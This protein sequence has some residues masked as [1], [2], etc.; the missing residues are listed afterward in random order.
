MIRRARQRR[1]ALQRG[2][3]AGAVSARK[4]GIDLERLLDLRDHRLRIVLFEKGPPYQGGAGSTHLL[5]EIAAARQLALVIRRHKQ[6]SAAL[7]TV[8]TGQTEVGYPLEPHVIDHTE[9]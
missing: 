2:A 7:A 6:V 1:V 8:G 3:D 9:R 5:N 4:I